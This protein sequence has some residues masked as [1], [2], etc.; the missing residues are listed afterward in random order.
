M[1]APQIQNTTGANVALAHTVYGDH[2]TATALPNS[3]GP[4]VERAT[5]STAPYIS[6]A[7]R[8]KDNRGKL[9][10]VD[11]CRAYPA[12][13]SGLEVCVGHARQQGLVAT[14]SE[15]L[16][17]KPAPVGGTLCKKHADGDAD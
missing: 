2:V 5:W 9:C 17:N 7:R 1:A 16:C 15:E 14:C 10:G 4:N 3:F 11:G 13:K 12:K 8:I 6:P